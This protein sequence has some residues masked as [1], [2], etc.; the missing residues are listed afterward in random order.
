VGF[1][2]SLRFLRGICRKR[3]GI[4]KGKESGSGIQSVSKTLR[5]LWDVPCCNSEVM[6][7]VWLL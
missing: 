1:E 6:R 7:G 5:K 2:E 3:R 4:I